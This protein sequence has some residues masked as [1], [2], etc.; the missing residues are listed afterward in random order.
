MGRQV[1]TQGPQGT[2]STKSR[3]SIEILKESLSS[4]RNVFKQVNPDY[5][6]SFKL[7]STLTLVVEHFF[8]QMRSR[9]DMP[10]ALEFAYLFTPAIRESLKQITDSGFLYFT[11]AK[12]YY[13][14]P[15][16]MKLRFRDLPTI[17]KP[18]S[19][20]MNKEEMK[21]I[22]DW[23]D[24]YGKPVRQLTV[25]NQ[26]T[27]DKVGTLPLYAYSAPDTEP[28]PIDYSSDETTSEENDVGTS[29]EETASAG[30]IVFQANSIVVI[31]RN[32]IDEF[33]QYTGP[34]LIGNIMVDVTDDELNNPFC[35]VE[36]FAPSFEDC[37]QF[38]FKLQMT[39]HRDAIV[40]GV[41]QEHVKREEN[42]LKLTEMSYDIFLRFL[43][44]VQD[45]MP[46]KDS[47]DETSDSDDEAHNAIFAAGIPLLTRSGRRINCPNRLDL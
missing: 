25:R 28:K 34:F 27:K 47:E 37:L 6:N 23:R 36:L 41:E 3:R 10:T 42:S 32:H 18:S 12:S 29:Q 33:S 19:V 26:S 24:S 14:L 43:N 9:N 20:E 4:L 40:C 31:K 13:E 21:I 17:P 11:S 44:D 46:E 39:I 7:V 2:V 35:D 30:A 8:S 16:E 15:E 5:L 1:A 38:N 45:V 22:R